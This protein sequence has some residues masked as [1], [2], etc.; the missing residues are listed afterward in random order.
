MAAPWFA[1]SGPWPGTEPSVGRWGLRRDEVLAPGWVA[2]STQRTYLKHRPMAEGAAHL[3]DGSTIRCLNVLPDA[4][5][6][7]VPPNASGLCRRN[8]ARGLDAGRWR[9]RPRQDPAA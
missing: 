4:I 6:T 9:P 3:L 7:L 2:T 5:G 1:A 8:R